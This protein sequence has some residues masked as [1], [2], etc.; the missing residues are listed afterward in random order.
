MRSKLKV[1]FLCTGNSCRS[2]MAEGW[3]R[4]LK[5]DAIDA[6]SAGLEPHGVTTKYY[7]ARGPQLVNRVVDIGSTIDGKVEANIENKAQGPAGENGARLRASLA[8]EGRKLAILG[9]DDAT[10]N[11]Q[12]VK[13]VMLRNDRELGRKYGLQYAEQFHY[14]GPPEDAAGKYVRENAVPRR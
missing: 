11:R 9:D 1:L 6:Y 10:A 4:R 3:A 7:F 14:I 12:Y 2:Q 5:P 13:Q 8:A